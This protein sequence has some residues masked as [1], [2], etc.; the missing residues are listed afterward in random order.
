MYMTTQ[1]LQTIANRLRLDV[2]EMIH[3]SGDGHPS[4][5][6][7]IADILAVL[8]FDVMKVRPDEPRWQDRDRFI[9]SKG[10]ACPVLYAALARRG[11]FGVE[12]LAGL[13]TLESYLQ[14]HPDMNK[15][16][17][18]DMVSGSLGTGVAIGMGM[19]K[20]LAMQG[21]D[22][23][24]YIIVGDGEQQ[25]GVIWEGAMAAASYK[26]GRLIVFADCNNY[27]SGGKVSELSSLYPVCDKWGAF[28]W[29]TQTIDGHD[30]DAIRQAIQNAKDVTDRPSFIECVTV[31]GKGIS[32][33]ENNNAWHKRT[34]TAEEVALARLELV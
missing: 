4:P 33:M 19:A 17:G 13:R 29:H 31:K 24:T 34:P 18:I 16:P 32:Y 5:C 10:H 12:E 3:A 25:E 28:H 7:S 14:G 2:M 9:L 27:Q 26:L 22:S 8:Y 30:I 6:M 11:F 15:T 21:S 20:G 1:E 23:Y